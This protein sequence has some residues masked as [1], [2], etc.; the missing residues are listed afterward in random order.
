MRNLY[1][2]ALL[3]F[4]FLPFLIFAGLF[5]G[6]MLPNP[7][8]YLRTDLSSLVMLIGSS[9]LILTSASLI[10]WRWARRQVQ[11]QAA[12]DHAQF[13]S[14]LRHELN[15]PLTAIGIGLA[16]LARVPSTEERHEALAGIEIQIERLNRLTA[17]LGRLANLE[18]NPLECIS[19][20]I[21]DLLQKTVEWAQEEHPET[22]NG[23]LTLIPLPKAWPLPAVSGD[24]DLLSLAVYN[25]L[26]NALKFTRPEDTIEIRAFEHRAKV[27]IEINDTGPG[28]PKAEQL[29]VW[30]E[31]YRGK[32][33]SVPG[34]GL[35]LPLVKAIIE[36]HGGEVTLES[37]PEQGTKVIIELPV[38]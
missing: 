21:S 5:W 38:E 9:V 37:Q 14:R 13:R 15:Q 25:L 29:D 23:R 10:L 26:N 20:D 30:K 17:V 8:V 22:E 2:L 31:L 19:V 28:I 18:T 36:R 27:V 32:D 6:G 33:V 16:R 24:E 11:A 3:G 7:I 1:I 12:R 35:G 34:S 4:L